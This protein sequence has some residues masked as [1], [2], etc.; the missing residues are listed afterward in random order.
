MK[1]T[2]FGSSGFIGSNLAKYLKE[3]SYECFLP[4]K[5]YEISKGEN[6]GHIIYCIGLTA[7]F[8]QRPMDTVKAH[9]CK[10]IEVIENS[11]FDSFLYLSSTRVYSGSNTGNENE[12]LSVNSSDFSDLYNISKLMGESICFSIPNNK[13]RVIRLS[14]VIGNDFSSDNFLFALIK[15]AVDKNEINLNL[16]LKTAKDYIK[17]EDV[18]KMIISISQKATH[19]IYN[20][21]SGIQISNE[22]ILN[23]IKTYT[24][25]KIQANALAN[26]LYFPQISIEKIQAEFNFIP[27]N[28]LDDIETLILNY[29]KSKT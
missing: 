7:D 22:Q 5:E 27:E 11:T 20:I 12:N 14:N 13:V 9:V 3:Q 8:R 1:Y 29:K 6:L 15:E 23:K 19:R 16:P 4:D 17:V 26:G 10:L 25:C 28:I 24:N 2:I 18:V 21:A